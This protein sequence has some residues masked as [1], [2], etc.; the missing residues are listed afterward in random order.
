M[1]VNKFNKALEPNDMIDFFD[2]TYWLIVKDQVVQFI[3][4]FIR[5]GSRCRPTS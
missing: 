2:Q 5:G 1:L 3:Q 4:G